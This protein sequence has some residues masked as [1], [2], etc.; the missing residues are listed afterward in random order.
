MSVKVAAVSA[1]ARLWIIKPDVITGNSEEWK[2]QVGTAGKY[3]GYV[4]STQEGGAQKEIG[5]GLI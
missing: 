4:M 5:R 1:V 2:S 3:G